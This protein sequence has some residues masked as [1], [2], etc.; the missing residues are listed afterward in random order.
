[1]L[2]A[3]V[4]P[5]LLLRNGGLVK[6]VK[7]DDPTYV[8]DPI[9]AVKIFNEKEVD[10]LV[11]LDISATGEGRGP[12]FDLVRDI[13]T[14]AFMPFGYGGGVTT[15]DQVRQLTACGAE[16]VVINTGAVARP[17]LITEAA[18]TVGSQSVV[19]A[20]DVSKS[21]FGRYEVVTHSATRKTGLDPVEWAQK[22]ERAG[23][24]EIL[25]NSVDRDGKMSGYDVALVRKIAD[26]V[27]V[28]VVACGGAG[29]LEHL[30]EAVV[31]GH[32]SAVSAGSL[33]VFHGKHRAVLI[34]YPKYSEL[35]AL[36]DAR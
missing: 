23:A 18:E 24:G 31:D 16:K 2:R 28:P 17:E 10:E 15:L 11:F 12:N 30:R 26:A 13:A 22:M 3:R 5:C 4:I 29:K 1:M 25:V 27:R 32:A 36:F 8:G 7:F 35:E 14:E 9:N 20:I 33:F 19:V 34:T 21:L 6:T